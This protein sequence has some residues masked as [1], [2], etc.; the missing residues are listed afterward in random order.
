MTDWI[1]LI[2]EA[3]MLVGSLGE[4]ASP[5]WWRSE[6]T[7]AAGIRF[8]ERL[9]PRTSLVASIET[10]SHAARL[11]HDVPLAQVGQYHLFRLPIA[12]E[13]AIRGRLRQ[14]QGMDD[15]RRLTGWSST[16]RFEALVALAGSETAPSARGPVNCGSI[17]AFHK[18]HT[19]QR[20]CAVYLAGFKN[21]QPV[22]PYLEAGP[23]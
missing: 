5:A 17:L 15:L 8:L 13:L 2:V 19:I 16:E 4:N 11:V 7:T 10:V 3:R 1:K 18:K 21:G 14:P 23:E 6:A 20:L 9:Y 12:D 22:Y